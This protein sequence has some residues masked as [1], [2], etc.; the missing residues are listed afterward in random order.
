MQRTRTERDSIGEM[1]IPAEA[2]YGIH[3]AR[4]VENFPITGIRL[5]HFPELVESLAMVKKAAAMANIE[6]KG[7]DCHIGSQLTELTP[8]MEAADKL[9]R[10]IDELAAEG[11][12]IHH[13]DVGGGLGVNY[14]A[15]QPPHPTEYAEALKQKLKR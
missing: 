15:E 1:Q 8:F 7:V 14:G 6:I 10:L 13:L 9:L 5:S 11:I 12:Q 3:T 2:D 4:A